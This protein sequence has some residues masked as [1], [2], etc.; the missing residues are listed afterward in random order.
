[1]KNNTC[2]RTRLALLTLVLAAG[3]AFAQ[4]P[5]DPPPSPA[6]A[7]SAA[8]ARLAAALPEPGEPK[9]FNKVITAEAKTQEGLFRVHSL[10]NKLYFEI[11]KALLEQP[12][13]MVANATAVPAGQEHVGRALNQDVLRFV[14]KN[15]WSRT[16]RSARRT[17]RSRRRC[18]CRS[19]MPSWRR[20][21]WRPSARTARR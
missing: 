4:T 10:K 1:M 13:L 9:P 18:A 21:P 11:P 7:A 6:A 17:N 16:T 2:G 19:V 20:C 5:T 14:L 15:S 8:M 3:R 12:L